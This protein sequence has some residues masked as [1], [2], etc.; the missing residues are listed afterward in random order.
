MRM[1]NSNAYMN[2]YMKKRYQERRDYAIF[3]LGGECVKCGS[4]DRL[5]FDHIDPAQKTF[6]FS[7]IWSYSMKVFG[8]EL[9]KAQLLCYTCHKEKTSSEQSKGHGGGLTGVRN[10]RCKLCAP[11]KNAYRQR[12]R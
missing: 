2:S 4:E 3:L 6:S 8:Q 1:A 9:M 7:K 5:E 12:Y 11:L 10:C